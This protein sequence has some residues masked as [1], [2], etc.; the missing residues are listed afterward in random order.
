MTSEPEDSKPD[1]SSALG[2]DSRD[3]VEP[4]GGTVI[5]GT[6]WFLTGR[7]LPQTYSV[8]TS[9]VAARALGVDNFGHLTFISFTAATLGTLLTLGLP[10]SIARHVAEAIGAGRED[11]VHALHRWAWR[12][13][14]VVAAIACAIL[15][16]VALAG[17]QPRAAWVLAGISSAGIV[18]HQIPS[19]FLYGTQRWRD[20]MIA[21]VSTGSVALVV[22]VVLLLSGGGIVG[23]MAIDAASAT[24]NVVITGMLGRRAVRRLAGPPKPAGPLIRNTIRFGLVASIGVLTTYVVFRRSELFFLEYFSTKAQIA[25]YSVPYSVVDTLL[26]I[27]GSVAFVLRPTFATLFGA[28][29][30]DRMRAGFARTLRVV[31]TFTIASG[32]YAFVVGPSALVLLYGDS[33]V[34]SGTVLRILLLSFPLVPVMQ[35]SMALLLGMGRQVFAIV[36]GLVAAVA[37]LLLDLV[38]IYSFDA[39]GAAVANSLAQ[40]VAS[41]PLLLY[42]RR[43]LGGVDTGSLAL[44]RALLVSTIAAGVALAPLQVLPVVPGLVVSS[45][46]FAIVAV[47][48]AWVVPVLRT[49]D[50]EALAE[51]IEGRA[52]GIPAAVVRGISGG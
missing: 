44:A 41:V 27:P 11:E 20:A 1:A 4:A 42:A 32:A 30:F 8:I 23:M 29:D 5:R 37:N 31:T 6:L 22:R 39:T 21:G 9:I 45:A 48:L 47:G 13:G 24:V 46:V 18:L 50:G 40:L 33:F 49:D 26:F 7:V 52:R 35:L 43:V 19:V 15:W 34:P 51:R 14:A 16:A 38:L 25:I 36:V 3:A 12:V 10:T 28:G 17:A 2:L